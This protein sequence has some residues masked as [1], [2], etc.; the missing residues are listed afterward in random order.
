MDDELYDRIRSRALV[1][2][3]QYYCPLTREE[4]SVILRAH[5]SFEVGPG[6]LEE[7]LGLE[8]EAFDA[9]GRRDVWLCPGLEP[10]DFYPDPDFLT[11]S[12]WRPRDRVV[13]YTFEAERRTWV[14]RRLAD[15]VLGFL[16]RRNDPSL[17]AELFAL[18]LE[19]VPEDLV[20]ERLGTRPRD[21]FDA[22]FVEAVRELAEDRHGELALS[23]RR[24][25][26]AAGM[27]DLELRARLFGRSD[28]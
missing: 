2:L 11:R 18:L 5:F 19:K 8:E 15:D 16:E 21:I 27:Q 23:S 22:D 1:V 6:D 3:D 7:V 4:L 25:G 17:F 13:E 20:R 12:D 10:P 28:E 14:L 9:G 24:G 26:F